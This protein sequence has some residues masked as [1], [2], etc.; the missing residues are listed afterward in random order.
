LKNTRQTG[1]SSITESLDRTS[2]DEWSTMSARVLAANIL[3]K[4]CIMNRELEAASQYEPQ[5]PLAPTYRLWI[6]DNLA[7]DAQ[8]S[9][10]VHAYDVAINTAQNLTTPLISENSIRGSLR[11]KA[12]AAALSGDTETAI[13]TY[14]E[15]ANMLP[16]DPDPLFQAGL[17]AER[18]GSD[19]RAAYFYSAV[20]NDQPSVDTDDPAELARRGLL[21]LKDP[22]TTYFPSGEKLAYLILTALENNDT[23]KLNQL[24]T[25]THFAIGPLAGHSMFEDLKPVEWFFEDLSKSRVSANGELV[26]SG[27]K[28][29]LKTCGW[30]GKWFQGELTCVLT[31]APKGWQWTGVAL[32]NPNDEWFERWGLTTEPV[33]FEQAIP[34]NLLAPWPAGLSFTAGG[35]KGFTKKQLQIHLAGPI[36]GPAMALLASRN[37]CGFGPRGFYYNEHF[38]HKGNDAYAIDFTRYKRNIPYDPETKGTPVLVPWEGEVNDAYGAESTDSWSSAN[39]VQIIHADPGDP[40]YK[41]RYMTRY[42]HF[43]GPFKIPVSKGMQVITGQRLGPMDDT[44]S[45]SLLHHLHFS[46][47]DRELPSTIHYGASIPPTPLNGVTLGDG[48]SGKCVF[49]TNVERF[50]VLSSFGYKGL[51]RSEKHPR[52]LADLT[53]DGR[54]DIIGFG[55]DAVVVAL[56]NGDG[57][58]QSARRDLQDLCHEAGG[59]MVERH[60]RFLADLTGGGRADII[61]FGDD[62]VFVAR[63][64]GNG[65]FQSA[66]HELGDFGFEAGGWR[67]ERHP[68]FV[69][70][71]T[72]N[73]LA[74][75]V[76]FGNDGVFVALNSGNGTFPQVIHG[77]ED[78]GYE[79]G[80]WR[81]DRHP[82]FLVDVTGSGQPDIVAFGNDGVFI[83]RN[84]SDGT[85]QPA[86]HELA[87]FGYEAGGW[88]VERHPRFV[89]DLTGNGLADIIGFGNDGVFVALN[90]GNGK[91]P[92]VIHGLKDLG[93][94]AGG[95]RVDRHPRLLADTTGDGLPD[96]VAFGNDGIFVARNNG[97]GTFQPAV[98]VHGDF[99]YDAGGWRVEK[100]PRLVEDLNGDGRAD[101]FGFGDDG[102]MVWLT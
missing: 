71:V 15:L 45:S 2:K 74:D 73:G 54:P 60:P 51:W 8:Y 35:I 82:R 94:E 17:T 14:Q 3:S 57:T 77:L 30:N 90:N 49:S 100:H 99:G 64:N 39:Y 23:D 93:Y 88:S 63:N 98:L 4:P 83:A 7:R 50:R 80:G 86:T 62:G 76:G 27:Q 97:D 89:V 33:D 24:I 28:R 66:T 22:D 85:F 52:F 81:A 38:S 26:G 9:Q 70:D 53:G 44:G 67:V 56:N 48:D 58:F 69:I 42:L 40:T 101:I 31:L 47:H 13:F 78:L 10:A 84:N 37:P 46:I 68:R 19:D 91:F 79:A 29:Y 25:K 87:D 72:G 5:S 61:A 75:I 32:S 92:E 16:G 21:R 6:A 12:K 34:L 1:N 36:A 43:D 65:T 95:W 96:I 59:W 20:M 55:T 18:I 41:N 11:H 102:I